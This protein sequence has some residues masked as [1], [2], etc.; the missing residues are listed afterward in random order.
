MFTYIFK[1]DFK[2]EGPFYLSCVS[3]LETIGV[4]RGDNKKDVSSL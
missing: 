1:L 3:L 4:Y 2:L